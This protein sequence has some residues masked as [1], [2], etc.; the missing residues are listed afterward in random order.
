MK[1]KKPTSTVAAMLLVLSRV[2]SASRLGGGINVDHNAG[3]DHPSHDT[4]GE[5]ES[6]TTGQGSGTRGIIVTFSLFALIVILLYVYVSC[7]NG[8]HESASDGDTVCSHDEE[9]VNS[10]EGEERVCDRDIEET[11]KN[12]LPRRPI[13]TAGSSIESQTTC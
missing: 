8:F 5:Q 7:C 2:S 13:N 4:T 1:Q 11:P 3:G 9:P 6:G 10:D 12:R